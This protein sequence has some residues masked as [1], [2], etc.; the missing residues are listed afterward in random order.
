MRSGAYITY[1]TLTFDDAPS[2]TF[3]FLQMNKISLEKNYIERK[4]E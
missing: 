4:S 2:A 1:I 3:V